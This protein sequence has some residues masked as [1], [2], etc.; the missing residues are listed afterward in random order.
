MD[1]VFGELSITPEVQYAY[2][3]PYWMKIQSGSYAEYY[4]I[5]KAYI[6]SQQSSPYMVKQLSRSRGSKKLVVSGD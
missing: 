4:N 5:N 2:Y 1:S 6:F 3:L